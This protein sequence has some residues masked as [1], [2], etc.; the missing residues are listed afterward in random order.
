MNVRRGVVI[1]NLSLVSHI[2][3]ISICSLALLTFQ[4][5]TFVDWKTDRGSV[6][7]TVVVV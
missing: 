6:V 2:N 5:G 1:K 4:A 3:F 7:L